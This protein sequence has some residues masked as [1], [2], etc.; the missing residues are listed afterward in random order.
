MIEVNYWIQ[1]LLNLKIHNNVHSIRR[2]EDDNKNFTF[3]IIHFGHGLGIFKEK[4]TNQGSTRTLLLH[5]WGIIESLHKTNSLLLWQPQNN[6]LE[7]AFT[8]ET[9]CWDWSRSGLVDINLI[10][11]HSDHVW[12]WHISIRSSGVQ[13]QQ[14]SLTQGCQVLESFQHKADSKP[15]KKE[16][17]QAHFFKTWQCVHI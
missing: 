7:T 17:T 16:Y 4:L 9:W 3:T 2:D 1:Q 15:T 11:I 13:E 12:W 14:E 5:A 8:L 10:T 6:A